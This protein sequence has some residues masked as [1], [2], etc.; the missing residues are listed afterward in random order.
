MSITIKIV[1]LGYNLTAQFAHDERWSTVQEWITEQTGL[2]TAYQ[3]FVSRHLNFDVVDNVDASSLTTKTLAE[4]GV[5]DRTKIMLLHSAQYGPERESYE[6]L[7]AVRAQLDQFAMEQQQRRTDGD[8]DSGHNDDDQKATRMVVVAELITRWC[9]QLDAIDTKDSATLRRM[10]KE[11][12]Q[13]AQAMEDSSSS[14]S[15]SSPAP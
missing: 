8:D 6:Q 7:L 10:R 9:C 5:Q 11:L 15:S 3:R 12:L 4:I 1:G 2:P 13:R 14:S